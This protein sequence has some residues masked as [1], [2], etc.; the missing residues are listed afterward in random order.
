MYF[1]ADAMLSLCLLGHTMPVSKY[2]KKRTATAS[3]YIT[4]SQRGSSVMYNNEAW[5]TNITCCL[6]SFSFF[7]LGFHVILPCFIER[8]PATQNSTQ[9]G[10]LSWATS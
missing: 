10:T 2:Y 8:Y 4:L 7:V 3:K 9:Y 5:Y 6:L 1:Q